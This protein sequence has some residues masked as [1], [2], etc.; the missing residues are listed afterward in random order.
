[1]S[2]QAP[3]STQIR[4]AWDAVADGFDRHVTP[5]TIGF[6]EH[7][8][9]PLPLGPGV[10]V[11]D[12]GAGS[13]GLAIPAARTGAEVVAVDIA[14]TMV[15]RLAERARDEGLDLDARVG[16]G[17]ALELED[18]AFDVAV[19]LNG[20][21]L[22][23]DL[24]R[25]LAEMVRVTRPDGRILIGTFGPLPEVEFI[26]YFIGALRT[27]APDAMPPDAQP[28]PPFRLADP[29]AFRRVL[30]EAGLHDVAI[31]TTTWETTFAS[32]DDFLD[33][34][35]TSNPIAGQ[36]TAGLDR[37]QWEQLRHVLDGMLRERSGGG[38]GATLTATMRIGRG[39][40]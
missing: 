22:F 37:D 17:T 23:P 14:P 2:T 15:E 8:L 6:G 4:D 38:A 10:R 30:E 11:L 13:G 26:A 5:H 24:P 18:D 31:E 25:G 3:S 1:M 32:V 39:T 16:D 21:S 40:V 12:V 19:S 7:L 9:A 33:L 36:V 20:V 34:L 28:L 29:S 35:L 27:V